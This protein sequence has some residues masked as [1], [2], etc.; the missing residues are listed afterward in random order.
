MD[1]ENRWLYPFFVSLDFHHGLLGI[2]GEDTSEA[3]ASADAAGLAGD[4][5][6]ADGPQSS[7]KKAN[8]P[9]IELGLP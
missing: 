1:C 3:D 5:A 6:E 7:P 4:V 2:V 9:I 8:A